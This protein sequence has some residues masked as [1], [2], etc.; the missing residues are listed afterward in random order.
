MSDSQHMLPGMLKNDDLIVEPALGQSDKVAC[1]V[2]VCLSLVKLSRCVQPYPDFQ[3]HMDLKISSLYAQQKMLI[4]F[5]N[6][7]SL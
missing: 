3:R 6:T 7:R 2:L 5:H 4:G 1:L